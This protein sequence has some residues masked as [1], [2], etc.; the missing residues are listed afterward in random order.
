MAFD[1]EGQAETVERK[2]SICRRAYRLLTET[3]GFPAQDIIF[4]PNIFAIATGIKEHNRLAINYIEATRQI[5]SVCPGVLISGGVSNLSFAFRGT[6]PVREA[7]HSAFLYHAIQAGMDMGIVNAG[8]VEVYEEIPKELLTL[9]ENVLFDRTENSTEELVN[10]AERVKGNGKVLQRD[11]AWRELPVEDRLS[12]ALVKGI[13]EYIEADTEEARAKYG[14]PLHVIEGPLMAGMNI[15]G[16]L[17]GSGKMFLPQVV[18]SARVMKLAVAYLTPYLESEKSVVRTNGR[19]LMATVKGD[20]HDIGK[21]I[22][23]VVLGCNN[24]E[25]IDL[26]VMVPADKILGA[27]RKQA[28]D[29]IGLSGLITPSLDEMVNVASEME[30]QG[31]SIPLLIG[32]ATTSKTHTAVKI[33]PSYS[34]PTVHVLDASQSVGVVSLLLSQD[35]SRRQ[36]F[37]GEIKDSYERARSDHAARVGSKE[38]VALSDARAGGFNPEWESYTIQ[39]P[40]KP[41]VHAFKDLPLDHLVDYIDWTPFFLSWELRGR[42][43]AIF[44]DPV[45]GAEAQSLYKSARELLSLLIREEWLTANGVVGLFPANRNGD[46]VVLYKDAGR[47][48][49]RETFHFLRQQRKKAAGQP[50]FSLADFIAPAEFGCDWIGGFAVTSG[51][52]IEKHVKR[53]ESAHDDFSALLLKALADRLA[54][55]FAEFLH[56]RVRKD[57]WGFSSSESLSAEDLI[58]ERYQGIRPAPGYPACPDHTEKGALWRLLDVEKNCG[59]ALTESLAMYP[60]ASVSGYYFAHPESQYF[61][62]G[63][64]LQDQLR[65]YAKRKGMPVEEIQAWLRPNLVD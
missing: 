62:L 61:G 26:G 27:A 55:A 60:A 23:G 15:V 44:D 19:I 30:R 45:V 3:V 48:E 34:G 31:F 50:Y 51:I 64:I 46:D 8:M 32:G 39:A 22:V 14:I 21:N 58:S 53:L 9:V 5:K 28:V 16:E 7:M 13:T 10:Y 1:E 41:G 38:Y 35:S 54:E 43:P 4:D 12:H 11:L 20:V 24:Y 18:K 33:E 2:V 42:Y 29:I 25:V 40:R 63:L 49:T 56:E 47:L 37:I 59:I 52:G 36:K 65:D 57:L 6:D 17:F